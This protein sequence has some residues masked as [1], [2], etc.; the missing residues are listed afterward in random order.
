MPHAH[1]HL[2]SVG[3]W[4]RG[5]RP[6]RLSGGCHGCPCAR[7]G[8]EE[9]VA[10]RVDLTTPDIGRCRPHDSTMVGVSVS[11]AVT[12][13]MGQLRRLDD[14]GEETGHCPG[15]KRGSRLGLI[16][17]HRRECIRKAGGDDLVEICSSVEVPEQMLSEVA[18]LDL[19][20]P[21]EL[22]LHERVGRVRDENLP[23]VACL[24]QPSCP[25]NRHAEVLA[26]RER[27]LARVHPHLDTHLRRFG[28]R[29]LQEQALRV[30]G[31][32]HSRVR[33]RE[34]DEESVSSRIDLPAAGLL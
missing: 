31:A 21:L 27:D 14:V 13:P 17:R 6:L 28:P 23:A 25:M 32:E 15:R 24:A 5:E 4:V 8:E 30:H 20:Q 12:K 10:L 26:V 3:P 22:I 16:R 33:P 2:P 29:V 34:G 11:P 18:K 9:R 19:G 7:K 1:A